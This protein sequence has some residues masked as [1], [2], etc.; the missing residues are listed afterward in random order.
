MQWN[1]ISHS[2]HGQ[3]SGYIGYIDCNVHHLPVG[4]PENTHTNTTGNIT[5]DLPPVVL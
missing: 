2:I 1:L 4:N 5:T 3:Y